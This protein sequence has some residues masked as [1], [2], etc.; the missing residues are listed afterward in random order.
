[1]GTRRRAAP[2]PRPRL[3]RK[4]RRKRRRRKNKSLRYTD[5][6]SFLPDTHYTFRL[7]SII[8]PLWPIFQP[9]SS[10]LHTINLFAISLAYMIIR[11]TFL[12]ASTTGTLPPPPLSSVL[13][14]FF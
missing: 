12:A 7:L 14:K 11:D 8:P 6:E 9:F 1:M 2:T 10:S 3:R 13:K 5:S 4:R